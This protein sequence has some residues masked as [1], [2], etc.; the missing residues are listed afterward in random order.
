VWVAAG[1]GNTGSAPSLVR[2]DAGNNRILATIDVSGSD[3]G[4]VH[5]LNRGIAFAAGRIWL[6]RDSTS[7]H[8][9]VVSVNP[10]TNRLDGGPVGVG[11]GPTTLLAAFGALWVESTGRTLG[12]K[13]APALPASINRIDPRTRRVTS[14]PLTGA[15]SAGFGSLWTRD[16][17]TIT[18]YVRRQVA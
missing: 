6:S 14:E 18:R 1:G 7:S 9:D 10:D 12:P 15:P 2:I 17:D 16:H 8:G 4:S 3:P 13:P 5:V 11:T